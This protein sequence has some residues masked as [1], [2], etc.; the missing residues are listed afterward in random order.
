MSVIRRLY[1]VAYG[2]VRTWQSEEAPEI[3]LPAS[4]HT[5]PA[6]SLDALRDALGRLEAEAELTRSPA[7]E[8]V[9]EPGKES[10]K[11]PEPSEPVTPES[12]KAP[13]TR[14]L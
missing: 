1:N 11:E 12:P 4:G 8:A 6:A 13:R 9:R 2:K 3:D 7:R 14:N 10:G 5:R